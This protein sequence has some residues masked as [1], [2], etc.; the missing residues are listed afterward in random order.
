VRE[1]LAKSDQ[2]GEGLRLGE[3]VSVSDPVRV[4]ER[5]DVTLFEALTGPVGEDEGLGSSEGAPGQRVP[6]RLGVMLAEFVTLS[7]GLAEKRGLSLPVKLGL[8]LLLPVR[9]GLVEPLSLVE[10]LLLGL[11]LGE[12]E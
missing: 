8:L 6:E 10:P 2:V 5:E 4:S 12:D 11:K 9:L 3:L 7:V 1:R